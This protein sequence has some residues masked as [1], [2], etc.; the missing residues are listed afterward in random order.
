MNLEVFSL[1]VLIELFCILQ[2]GIMLLFFFFLIDKMK[3]LECV[4]DPYLGGC[5]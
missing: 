5:Q 3:T 4:V 2:N 1:T